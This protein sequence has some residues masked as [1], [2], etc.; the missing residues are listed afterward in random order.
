[1]AKGSDNDFPSVLV[2]EQASKPTAPASGKQRL[3][4][5]TDHKLYHEDDGGTETEVGGGSSGHTIQDE[6]TP[7]TARTNL[8]FVGSGVAAT[9]DSGNDATVVTISGS[10][11]TPAT[12]AAALVTAYNLFR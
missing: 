10:G 4:M 6:G 5:K 9:D 2:T 8:N 12:N 1:M 11:G 3:Y 7:L